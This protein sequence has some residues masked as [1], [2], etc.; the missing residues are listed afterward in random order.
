[1]R[2][3]LLLSYL[4]LTLVILVALEVPLA[5]TYRE[6]QRAQLEADLERDAFVLASYAE[7]ALEGTAEVDL[8]AL[9]AGYQTRTGGRV[10]I[11]D[12]SGAMRADSDPAVEGDRSFVGRPEIDTALASGV[13]AGIRYSATLDT[14]LLYVA[15]PVSSGGIVHGAVRITYPTSE[16]DERVRSYW[17]LLGGVAVISL[18]VATALGILLARWVTRPVEQLRTAATAIG[19]GAL[20]TR[21]PTGTGPPEV[22]ELAV[23][24]NTTA[25]RL[26][27]LVSAQ[28]QFVADASHELRTP[29]TAL[30]LRLEML[31]GGPDDP[32][33]ADVAAAELEVRR[34]SRLVE[35]L[36]D[37]ARA[38]RAPTADAEHLDVDEVLSGRAEIW[39]PVAEE[40]DVSLRA[41]PSHLTVFATADRVDQVLD[42]LIANAL[43]AAPRHS[44]VELRATAAG[45]ATVELHVVDH[46]KGLTSEQRRRAF[47]RFWRAD[48]TRTELGGSGIGLALVRKLA[49]A[50]GGDAELRAS[51]DGGVD[52]V[53][54]LPASS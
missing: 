33:A 40:R 29:L 21:A 41:K 48:S 1:M 11:V 54:V 32:A 50:D 20:D 19:H 47:D 16:L 53:V 25:R 18:G 27:E 10:V 43:D 49:R 24:F 12:Q 35:S 5:T 17:L 31:E 38:D 28:E 23:A 26:E 4:A 7:D 6:R 15:V 2:R 44:S 30:R 14:D 8:E 42:N 13:A 9:A 3:R 37:L 39:G 22:R 51:P 46:G 36:L 34:L 52:A 45:T